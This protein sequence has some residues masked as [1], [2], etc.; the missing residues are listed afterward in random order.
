MGDGQATFLFCLFSAINGLT[1]ASIFVVYTAGS[2]VTTESP[3][4][5]RI[6]STYIGVS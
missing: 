3:F 2:I 1:L 4:F 5:L 6:V